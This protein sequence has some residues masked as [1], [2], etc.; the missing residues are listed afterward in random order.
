MK[1]PASAVQNQ[2]LFERIIAKRWLGKGFIILLG[3]LAIWKLAV[4]L[5]NNP[6]LFL[7]QVLNGLQL[8][9]VYALIAL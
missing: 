4:S 9:F 6:T 3:L 8:C 2:T 1:A 5:Q 7:Q